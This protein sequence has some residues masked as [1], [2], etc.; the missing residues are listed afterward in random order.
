MSD[1]NNTVVGFDHWKCAGF[2][3]F[4]VNKENNMKI[5]PGEF[6]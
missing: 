6:G 4:Y 3:N 1:K 5:E 2:D